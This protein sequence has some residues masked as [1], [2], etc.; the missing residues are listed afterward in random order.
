MTANDL[1]YKEIQ[2]TFRKKRLIQLSRTIIIL[3]GLI[4]FYNTCIY[5]YAV[6]RIAQSKN[7]GVYPT[8][9][10]AANN[11]FGQDYRDAKLV[12]VTGIHC[13]P[14][15]D[16]GKPEHVWFCTARVEY[17]RIPEGQRRSVFLDGSF[18]IKVR[19][20]WVYMSEG[21]FPGMVGGVMKLFHLEGTP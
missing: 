2:T 7:L 10:E 14:N 12:S 3:A 9:Q 11:T 8:A 5:L 13:A 21:A 15:N 6:A 20:G 1:V 16:T 18:F 17:D 4:L 19:D